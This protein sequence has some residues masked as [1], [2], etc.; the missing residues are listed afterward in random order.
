MLVLSSF[1]E[2]VYVHLNT[3]QLN[4]APSALAVQILAA[5]RSSVNKTCDILF[6]DLRAGSARDAFSVTVS[7]V[8]SVGNWR[9]EYMTA[10]CRVCSPGAGQTRELEAYC[11]ERQQDA[12]LTKR[13]AKAL[14]ASPL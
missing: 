2:E 8:S 11:V 4:F 12:P 3:L 13:A 14:Q 10:H 1:N 5:V 7:A 6:T 9:S